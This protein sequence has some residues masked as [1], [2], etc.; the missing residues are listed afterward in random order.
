MSTVHALA[1]LGSS[2]AA[3]R[4]TNGIAETV[5]GA[6]RW[7]PTERTTS[8]TLAAGLHHVSTRG[9]QLRARVRCRTPNNRAQ[10]RGSAIHRP[11]WRRCALE[12][13]AV[14]KLGRTSLVVARHFVRH[15]VQWLK[16]CVAGPRMGT[17]RCWDVAPV[18]HESRGESM[19]SQG[20]APSPRAPCPGQVRTPTSFQRPLK[21]RGRSSPTRFADPFEPEPDVSR[22]APRS[23]QTCRLRF[24]QPADGGAGSRN[25]PVKRIAR[26]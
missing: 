20:A 11:W 26:A 10:F 14:G 3:P 13:A 19:A 8:P 5:S 7:P 6:T 2:F 24:T 16:W 9:P 22:T 21:S 4:S 12:Y 17:S 1:P 25:G 15:V 18:R 23:T